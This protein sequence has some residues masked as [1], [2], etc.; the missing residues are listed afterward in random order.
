LLTKPKALCF[1]FNGMEGFATWTEDFTSIS[2]EKM[3][4]P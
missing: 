2:S 1:I 4:F 3:I